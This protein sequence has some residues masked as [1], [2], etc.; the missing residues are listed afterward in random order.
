MRQKPAASTQFFEL[1]N[2]YFNSRCLENC[3]EQAP[4]QVISGNSNTCD[5]SRVTSFKKISKTV[6]N[7]QNKKKNSN[8]NMQVVQMDI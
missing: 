1:A 4:P 8:F 7:F 6:S 3:K 2:G 5:I